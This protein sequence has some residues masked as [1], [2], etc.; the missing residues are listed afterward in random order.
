MTEMV[1]P[2][3]AWLVKE[4]TKNTASSINLLIERDHSMP[5]T[6]GY[7][8]SLFA[9]YTLDGVKATIAISVDSNTGALSLWRMGH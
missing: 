2:F 4:I 5:P 7:H 6:S 9:N 1:S 3:Q 8:L